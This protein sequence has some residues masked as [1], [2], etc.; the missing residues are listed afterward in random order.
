[1][2]SGK[3]TLNFLGQ[4]TKHEADIG[5][6]KPYFVEYTPDKWKGEVSG[7]AFKFIDEDGSS[8]NCLIIHHQTYGICLMFDV[9]HKKFVSG[10]STVGDA[11]RMHETIDVGSDEIYP[12]GCFISPADAWPMV[13]QYLLNPKEY[14]KSFLLKDMG[15]IDW[16]E[17]C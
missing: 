12:V 11:R 1:M 13:E 8:Y 15:E 17:I 7:G 5:F 4:K 16:P 6:Y 9:W 3:F 10:R 14:P 2:S